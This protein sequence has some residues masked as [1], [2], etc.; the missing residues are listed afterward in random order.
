MLI[1]MMPLLA[2]EDAWFYLRAKDTLFI[3]NFTEVNNKLVYRGNDR[4]LRAVLNKYEISE[5]KKTFRNAKLPNLK[6]TFF[7]IANKK[8]MMEDLLRNASHVF[9]FGEHISEEDKKIFEPNDYGLTSTIGGNTGLQADLSYLDDIDMPK[10]WFYTTGSPDV[11]IGISDG[12]V[13]TTNTDFKDKTKVFNKSSLAGGHGY[14]I[15]A[16]AAAQGDNGYGIPGVC[17]DCSIYSTNYGDFRNL[18]MIM[19]LSRAG[20]KVVNCSWIGKQYY[21]TAQAAVDEMFSNGTLIVAAG[22]NKSWG[23]TKGELLYYPA[24][25]KHVISVGVGTFRHENVMDNIKIEKNGNYY[26]ENVR[27]YVGRTLGFKNNDTLSEPHIWAAG[28][29]TLNSEID[30]LAPSTG[31]FMFSKFI[32]DGTLEYH[33]YSTTS[34]ATPFV[35]GTIGLM[36]SLYPCLPLDEVES[37]LK[38]S[39]V[40]IDHIKANKPYEGTYGAGLLNAGNTIELLYQLHTEDEIASIENQMFSRWD[41]KLT[42]YSKQVHIQNMEF[43]KDATLDLVAKNAIV[44]GANT[45]LKPSANGKI[46]LKVDNTIDKECEL[47]LRQND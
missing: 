44:L 10:A 28:T 2:Q 8:E 9:V 39:A 31:Q 21:E 14:S 30:I 16:N 34:G 22:G 24:S 3:P 41:F 38:I 11:I 23:E 43:T 5:F 29:S 12:S 25:Y 17:Y 27:G 40:N 35:T 1:G 18:A 33:P 37:I 15:A 46:R 42:A 19:E 36:F 26:A 20:A 47:R 45:V 13:D 32:L 4:S 7:V 6:K